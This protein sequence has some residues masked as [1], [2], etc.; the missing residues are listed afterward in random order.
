MNNFHEKAFA[1]LRFKQ[2]LPL[3]ERIEMAQQIK[4]RFPTH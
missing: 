4:K 1:N 2:K 3:Q